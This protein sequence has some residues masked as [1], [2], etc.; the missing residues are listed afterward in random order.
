MVRGCVGGALCHFVVEQV[1]SGAF[2][3]AMNSFACAVRRLDT[4]CWFMLVCVAFSV[5][6]HTGCAD[7]CKI[8]L[9]CVLNTALDLGAG[10]LCIG[11]WVG[12]SYVWLT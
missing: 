8:R 12:R 5:Y 3:E 7:K 9:S 10:A 6:C 1:Y 4:A 2:E 11:W